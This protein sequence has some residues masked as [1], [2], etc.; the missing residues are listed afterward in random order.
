MELYFGEYPEVYE[1]DDL[2]KIKRLLS[3][4]KEGST[5]ATQWA[6]PWLKSLGQ[7]NREGALASWAAMRNE[8]LSAFGDPN[9]RNK[10]I[11]EMEELKQQGSAQT[12]IAKFRG[13]AQ[14]LGWGERELKDKF[15]SGLKPEVRL[16]LARAPLSNPLT[17]TWRLND[18][19]T[20]AAQIDDV[21]YNGRKEKETKDNRR[22]FTG[23]SSGSTN[24]AKPDQKRPWVPAEE[25]AR[26]RK[27][28]LCI[29]C[30]NTGHKIGDCRTGWKERKE[31]KEGK[32][33]AGKHAETVEE[34]SESS[35]SEKE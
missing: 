4:V 5:A 34:E 28:N 6:L 15:I 2:R 8:F 29:K 26:R 33:V 30:G 17:A 14:E 1:N 32:K 25:I 13:L 10:A 7:N 12:Y 27:E 24:P 9:R 11:K 35:E 21:L 19:I 20:Y 31:G 3:R 18:W 22:P 23:K 16:E